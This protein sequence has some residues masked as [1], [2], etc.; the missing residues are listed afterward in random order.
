M[1]RSSSCAGALPRLPAAHRLGVPGR[2]L[3]P[4]SPSGA[5]SATSLSRASSTARSRPRP[6]TPS[7]SATSTTPTPATRRTSRRAP[8]EDDQLFPSRLPSTAPATSKRAEQRCLIDIAS[9]LVRPLQRGG[10][11]ACSTAYPT[12]STSPCGGPVPLPARRGRRPWAPPSPTG[13]APHLGV[14]LPRGLPRRRSTR[15]RQLYPLY[16]SD[17]FPDGAIVDT[18]TMKVIEVADLRRPRRQPFWKHATSPS[19]I[20]TCL[21]PASSGS[22]TAVQA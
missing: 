14:Q 4:S 12:P 5:R 15:S 18:R 16:S 3:T 6:L 20:P 11:E 10:E 1:A 17:S 2:S 13:P 7:P 8:A 9:V 19:S 21:L 22:V